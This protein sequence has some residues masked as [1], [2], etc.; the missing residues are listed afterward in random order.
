[1]ASPLSEEA[2][3]LELIELVRTSFAGH[4]GNTMM[5]FGAVGVLGVLVS[6]A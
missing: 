6:L 2:A 4:W 3:Q 1:M 5:A